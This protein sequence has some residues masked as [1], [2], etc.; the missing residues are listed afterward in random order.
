MSTGSLST[1]ALRAYQQATAADPS[2]GSGALPERIRRLRAR[3]VRDL[4]ELLGLDPARVVAIDDPIRGDDL[5]GHL[6]IATDPKPIPE[7]RWS[8]HQGKVAV[9]GA[10]Y[11]RYRFS[12]NRAEPG[13]F[14]LLGACP[15]CG[16]EVPVA[17]ITQLADL[18]L[19]LS[20]GRTSDPDPWDR[21]HVY[22]CP[23]RVFY[24]RP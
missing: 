1:R 15:G 23:H 10:G 24:E 5:P 14:H 9:D 17:V 18:G 3:S 16:A 13:T 7:D 8:D 21:N 22:G 20:P 11:R 2:Y 19:A 6:L 4:A 12:P